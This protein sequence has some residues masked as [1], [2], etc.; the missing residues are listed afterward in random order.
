MQTITISTTVTETTFTGNVV[1]APTGGLKVL[2]AEP[3]AAVL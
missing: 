3:F 1:I 2:E